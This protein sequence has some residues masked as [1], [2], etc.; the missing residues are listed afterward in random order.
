MFSKLFR[1][2]LSSNKNKI[3]KQIEVEKERKKEHTTYTRFMMQVEQ[4]VLL[5]VWGM[6]TNI[7][8]NIIIN[9]P[10]QRQQQRM[11]FDLCTIKCFCWNRGNNKKSKVFLKWIYVQIVQKNNAPQWNKHFHFLFYQVVLFVTAECTIY[12]HL[13]ACWITH[14]SQKNRFLVYL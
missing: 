9:M 1:N 3:L 6:S 11:F 4:K 10:N 14:K 2:K 7:V 5:I 12:S 13:L 8:M